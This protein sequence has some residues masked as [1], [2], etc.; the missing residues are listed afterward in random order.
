LNNP[1][2]VASEY[3]RFCKPALYTHVSIISPVEYT[4][5]LYRLYIWSNPAFNTL[6][7][8]RIARS[9]TV[10]LIP[11]SVTCHILINLPAPS[12][13]AASYNVLSTPRIA[14]R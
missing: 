9:A 10:V 1:T 7:R 5:G 2:A 13:A 3:W 8:D 12:A 11:G 14:A 6:P 4:N